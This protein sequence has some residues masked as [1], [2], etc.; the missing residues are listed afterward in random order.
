MALILTI[1]FVVLMI[2]WF[3]GG[4]YCESRG[5]RFDFIRFGSWTLIPW[6]CVAIL[7]YLFFSGTVVVLPH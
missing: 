7:G 6:A 1:V 4:G 3:L 2:L 5:E